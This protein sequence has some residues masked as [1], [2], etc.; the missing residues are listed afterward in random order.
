[1]PEG[2]KPRFMTRDS[3]PRMARDEDFAAL[4][5]RDL[6]SQ[7]S[8]PQDVLIAHIR[9]NPFQAR[10]SFEGI[11]ELAQAIRTH[12]FTS[13][14]RV[15]HDPDDPSFFQ[16]VFGERRLRAAKEAGLTVVPCDVAEHTDDEL[17]EIGLTENLQRQDLA[18]LEEARAL[19]TLI[20]ERGYTIRRLAERIGKDKGYIQNR[21]ALLQAAPDV[22]EMLVHRPDTISVARDIGKV[23]TAEARRP[24]IEGVVAGTLSREDVRAL[25][26][27]NVA[28]TS[29]SVTV[30]SSSTQPSHRDGS[31]TQPAPSAPLDRALD[32][33]IPVLRTIFA[34]W[35]LAASDFNAPQRERVLAFIEEHRTELEHL[36]EVLR[37]R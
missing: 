30:P 14:L 29:G 17:I 19:Q 26:R 35:R 16:L 10:A 20:D 13:R 34:R 28:R 4:F 31:E 7:P 11:D 12:G 24:L 1:M 22:Q 5:E 9:P 32:R 3:R 37:A 15:R 36:T 25:V 8:M 2:K 21:L 23:A 18:P 33:D 6:S 27:D